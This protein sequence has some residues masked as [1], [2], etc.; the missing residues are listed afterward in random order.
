[1]R[2]YPLGLTLPE[3]SSATTM[4]VPKRLFRYNIE[5]ASLKKM[6]YVNKL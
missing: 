1:L 3:K 2:P 5:I 6:S 4:S